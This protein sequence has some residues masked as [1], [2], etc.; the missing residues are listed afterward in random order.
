MLRNACV[1]F[2][3]VSYLVAAAAAQTRT[4]DLLIAD[5][6][7]DDYGAWKVE[8]T[9]F[10][11]GPAHGTL[12]GQMAVEGFVGKGLVN[13]FHGGDDSTGMLTSPSFKVQR[14]HLAFLIGG[15]GWPET[16][17]NLRVD[18]KI[19]RTATGPNTQPGGSERLEAHQRGPDNS[20]RQEA[21]GHRHECR[22]GNDRGEAVTKFSGEDRR[23]KT[24]RYGV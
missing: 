10:G 2:L 13:S 11:T 3:S 5:F 21:T 23:A 1:L 22:T 8:G 16:C 14:R 24:Q 18:G 9:A 20:D 12:P 15:G 7:G 19:V 6:E 4:G 17:M